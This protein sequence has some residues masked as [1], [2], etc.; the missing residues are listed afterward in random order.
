LALSCKGSASIS[1]TRN[2][3]MKVIFAVFAFSTI[4]IRGVK[5]Y[6]SE[7]SNVT[8]GGGVKAFAA[9]V[10]F[11]VLNAKMAK[12]GKQAVQ[13]QLE[14]NVQLDEHR[15]PEQAAHEAARDQHPIAYQFVGFGAAF[16][17]KIVMNEFDD[18]VKDDVK[19]GVKEILR[20]Y[21]RGPVGIGMSA[22]VKAA[23]G[24]V[25]K[26]AD[27]GMTAARN[28]IVPHIVKMFPDGTQQVLSGDPTTVVRQEFEV[29][30]LTAYAILKRVKYLGMTEFDEVIP[31]T[32]EEQNMV[33]MID[34]LDEIIDQNPE[35]AKRFA[36]NPEE[37]LCFFTRMLV[38]GPNS[39][40]YIFA[41][42]MCKLQYQSIEYCINLYESARN[43]MMMQN[44]MA[45]REKYL[46]NDF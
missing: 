20:K 24:A 16:G 23:G 10:N 40:L 17:Q 30:E 42:T 2:T 27:D 12:A 22:A 26:D 13:M 28:N 4:V 39:N 1:D 29:K 11:A 6:E 9:A 25:R 14:A 32:N 21:G 41:R 36:Q 34:Q 18:A 19:K 35:L 38:N 3:I 45:D 46:A 33:T 15:H 43:T 31:I 37:F 8:K 7:H 5:V 44:L